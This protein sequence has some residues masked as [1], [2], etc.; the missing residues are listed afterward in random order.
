MVVIHVPII[1][2]FTNKYYQQ[3]IFQMDERE[4]LMEAF[5][6]LIVCCN[7]THYKGFI[8]VGGTD[9]LTSIYVPNYPCL[10]KMTLKCSWPVS[11]LL[12]GHDTML[13]EWIQS[14]TLTSFLKKLKNLLELEM[15]KKPIVNECQEDFIVADSFKLLMSDLKK[16]K[17]HNIVSFSSCLKKI[18]LQKVDASNRVHIIDMSVGEA[19]P[20]DVVQIQALLPDAALEIIRKNSRV[21]KIYNSFVEQ[22]I[23]L[24]RT[25]DDLDLIDANCCVLDPEHPTRKDMGRRILIGKNVSIYLNMSY[26]DVSAVPS[27]TVLGP[28]QSVQ[29][30]Q[31][32]LARNEKLWDSDSST[33]DNL[34]KVLDLSS[35]PARENRCADISLVHQEECLICF[36]LWMDGEMPNLVCENTRC[37]SPFHTTCL[38]QWLQTVSGNYQSFNQVH[39]DCPNCGMAIS[40]PVPK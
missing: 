18:Q 12:S 14:D 17:F 38:F 36:A 40:C 5:P 23:Y 8:S 37:G 13:K 26:E 22:V 16:I 29:Q 3:K 19:Y 25:W 2:P 32:T 4:A 24:Q 39:G 6:H 11:Q 7:F 34:K 31:S 15:K 27:I 1:L 35:F 33:V 28:E 9:F 30:F 10:A 21:D 20:L